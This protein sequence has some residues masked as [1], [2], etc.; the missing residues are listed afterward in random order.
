ML[1]RLGY[2]PNGMSKLAM[3]SDGS[4]KASK[5]AGKG[6]Q[7]VNFD[8]KKWQPV[9]VLGNYGQAGPVR[10][11]T[12]DQGGDDRFSVPPGFRVEMVVPS[13]PN[14]DAEPK[15]PFSLINMTF[16]NKGRLLVSRE[17]GRGKKGKKGSTDG[18]GIYL[19]TNRT[20]TASSRHQ[21]LLRPGQELPG[22]VLGQGRPAAGR[23]GAAGERACIACADTERRRPR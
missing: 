18:G 4:W 1:V 2:I 7:Q 21:A 5:T 12:W 20:R 9:R 23:R 13:D 6:W 16:D 22:H 11:V 19:C 3:V 14:L 8:D 17:A 10:D 15:Q